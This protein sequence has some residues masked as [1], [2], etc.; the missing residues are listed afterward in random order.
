MVEQVQRAPLFLRFA[1]LGTLLTGIAIIGVGIASLAQLHAGFSLGVGAMLLFYG[2]AVIVAGW[3]GYRE[4]PGATGPM[5][6][7]A[8]LHI[9]SLLSFASYSWWTIPLTA[10]PLATLVLA[11]LARANLHRVGHSA[12]E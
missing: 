1:G 7:F 10:I 4:R 6:A 8:L 5:V 9:A 2:G 12:S 11:V 3:F